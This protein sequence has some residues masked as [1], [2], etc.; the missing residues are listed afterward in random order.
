MSAVHAEV[1]VCWGGQMTNICDRNQDQ[2]AESGHREL[3]SYDEES[4]IE[5]CH[6]AKPCPGRLLTRAGHDAFLN[7]FTELAAPTASPRGR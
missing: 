2:H 6:C 4:G 3:R 7:R 5:F 1:A